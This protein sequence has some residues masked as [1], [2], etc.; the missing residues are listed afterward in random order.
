MTTAERINT[1]LRDVFDDESIEI[2]RETT[3]DDVDGWDSLS[4]VNVILAVETTFNIRFGPKEVLTFRNV[5]DM[6]DC[7]ERKLAE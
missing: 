7:I 5:G 1:I 4:H 6:I 2:T 3:A